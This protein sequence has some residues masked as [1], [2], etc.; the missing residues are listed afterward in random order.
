MSVAN[1]LLTQ[2]LSLPAAQRA[3]IAHHLL[4]SLPAEDDL[5]VIADEELEAEIARRI[6]DYQSGRAKTVDLDT[7]K[8]TLSEAAK[9]SP[10]S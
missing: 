7:L 5:P 1:E 2:A 8:R 3:E 9:G 6:E 4:R 10:S